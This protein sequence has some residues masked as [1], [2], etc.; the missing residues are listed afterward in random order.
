MSSFPS[1]RIE[2]QC[3]KNIP[4][5]KKVM[6]ISKVCIFVQ[7]SYGS[8][9]IVFLGNQVT[10]YLIQFEKSSFLIKKTWQYICSFTQS[11]GKLKPLEYSNGIKVTKIANNGKLHAIIVQEVYYQIDL[12]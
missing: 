9:T 6:I 12:L 7:P 5:A 11:T 10:N 1:Y 2:K 4:E 8:S 3:L